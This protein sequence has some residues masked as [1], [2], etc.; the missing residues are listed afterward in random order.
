VTGA[1][2]FAWLPAG[3]TKLVDA[4]LA[5]AA[6][7]M[8]VFP[9]A[10]KLPL[11]A[12]GFRDASTDANVVTSW[13]WHR[14]TGIGWAPPAGLF[15]LDVD[16]R[17]GGH[18][19]LA[20]LERQHGRLPTTLEE[21]TGSGG[22]H[23]VMRMPAGIEAKQSAGAIGAGLDIRVGGRGYIVVA[24]SKHPDTGLLYRWQT[25][26]PVADAPAWL[27]ALVRAR[28]AAVEQPFKPSTQADISDRYARAVLEGEAEAVAATGEGGRNHRLVR[29]W[30]RCTRDGLPIDRGLVRAELTRAALAAGL[31]LWEIQR[32]LREAA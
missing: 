17:H 3:T 4:A 24:P 18:A 25:R 23:V 29:A 2:R 15:V 32:T 11:T 28:P 26:A 22:L 9:V 13:N 8:A 1:Q 31:P 30:F 7:R 14:A 19:T 12:H 27:V 21:L 20:E 10:G 6:H 16:G 5:Y